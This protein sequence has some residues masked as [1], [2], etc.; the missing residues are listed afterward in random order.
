MSIAERCFEEHDNP[1]HTIADLEGE[2]A[3]LRAQVEQL[4]EDKESLE[5]NYQA[6]IKG[7]SDIVTLLPG[8]HQ[9]DA[10]FDPQAA[11]FLVRREAERL[12]RLRESHVRIIGKLMDATDVLQRQLAEARNIP[13][14]PEGMRIT[15][16]KGIF[17]LEDLDPGCAYCIVGISTELA[18]TDAGER[19]KG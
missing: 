11:V 8:K 15:E 9:W 2:N 16:F 14:L 10:R 18:P 17:A 12:D 6:C 13:G 1:A 5:E 3:D 7:L 19:K 4:K